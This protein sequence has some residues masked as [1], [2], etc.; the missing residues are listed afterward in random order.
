MF[1]ILECECTCIVRMVHS[2]T[3]VFYYCS[4]QRGETKE[5]KAKQ[6]LRSYTQIPYI[7]T[8]RLLFI[9]SPARH[10]YQVRSCLLLQNLSSLLFVWLTVYRTY[11][12]WTPFR[13]ETLRLNRSLHVHN[14]PRFGFTNLCSSSTSMSLRT[15]KLCVKNYLSVIHD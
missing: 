15:V 6:R 3:T 1:N 11:V 8:S 12:L 7:Q 5:K 14:P 2:T 9:L 13:C 10:S 4:L